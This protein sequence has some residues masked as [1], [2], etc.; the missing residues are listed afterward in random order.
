MEDQV[1]AN[2][3]MKKPIHVV[4]NEWV[5]FWSSERINACCK[6]WIDSFY[7][8]KRI[9]FFLPPSDQLNHIYVNSL[10]HL[11]FPCKK[12]GEVFFRPNLGCNIPI[13]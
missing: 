4:I 2:V 11:P 5:T 3:L 12:L 7:D 1:G 13:F 9:I 8:N 10:P 6:K